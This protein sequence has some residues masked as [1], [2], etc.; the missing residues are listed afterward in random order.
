MNE[1]KIL[2]DIVAAAVVLVRVYPY[3]LRVRAITCSTTTTTAA[4][5]KSADEVEIMK[6]VCP[7]THSLI[8]RPH[9]VPIYVLNSFINGDV[10]YPP[11]CAAD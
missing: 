10:K 7:V 6:E 2:V 9:V 5:S 1:A 8:S 4:S 11:K 3:E